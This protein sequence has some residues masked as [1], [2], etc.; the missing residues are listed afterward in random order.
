M[1]CPYKVTE[2]AGGHFREEC[3]SG[4]YVPGGPDL[5]DNCVGVCILKGKLL[6]MNAFSRC[7]RCNVAVLKIKGACPNMRASTV[8]CYREGL[9]KTGLPP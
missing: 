4:W 7:P 1:A 5:F 3:M 8:K 9:W 2:M 6:W